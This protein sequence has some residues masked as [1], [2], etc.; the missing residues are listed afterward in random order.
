MNATD[1]II[2]VSEADFEYQVV[3]YSQ[4]TPVVVDFWAEWCGPCRTL[5]PMLER[6]AREANGAF[7]LAKVDVDK[8]PA[9]ARRFN[10]RSIPSVKAF[11]D[12]HVV[13]EFMGAQPESRVREFLK[14]V[15]PSE[16]NLAL[17][18]AQSLL[19]NNQWTGAEKA[20]RQILDETPEHPGALL[21][22][23]KT[24][25]FQGHASEAEQIIRRFPASR[26]LA[27]VETIRPLVE[28]MKWMKAGP[29]YSDDPLEAASIQAIRLITRGNLPAAMDG[30]LD[31]LREDRHYRNDEARKV[32]LA[33]FEMLGD[34]NPLTEQYRKELSA[35][36]F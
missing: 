15:A 30:L 29:G 3:A 5:G 7:R 35:V 14:E 10:V 13:A 36:L 19:Q 4:E 12:A 22:L 16:D 2:D 26:E 9:L 32:M 31:I 11:R 27:A 8:N 6:L 23:L 34:E 17:E 21:G 28:A 25:L 18:K 33:L 1:N 24:F 20:F